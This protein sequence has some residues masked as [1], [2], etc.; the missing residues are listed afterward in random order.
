[1]PNANVGSELKS[2]IADRQVSGL[3]SYKERRLATETT[4][5]CLDER[6]KHSNVCHPT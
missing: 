5:I 3:G 6:W 4:R 2:E 1:M